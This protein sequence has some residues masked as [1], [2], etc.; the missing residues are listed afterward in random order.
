M[1]RTDFHLMKIQAVGM[2]I[3][4]ISNTRPAGSEV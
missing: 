1:S 3:I 4:N 2:S